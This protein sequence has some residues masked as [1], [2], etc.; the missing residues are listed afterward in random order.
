MAFIDG[1]VVTVALPVL[2]STF[3]ASVADVQWII[4]SYALLLSSLLLAGGAA[5]DLFGRRLVYIAGTT[6]FALAS[7]FCGLSTDIRMLIVSRAVQGIGAALLV[8]GS[9]AII[10]ASFEEK[11]RGRAIGTWSGFT[12]ITAA[13]GPVLGGWLVEHASWRWIFFI[14]VPVAIVVLVLVTQHVPE[15]KGG[16]RD[17][18]LDWIGAALASVGLGGMV[19]GLI[20]SSA[21]GW[22]DPTV[23]G[24]MI[25]GFIALAGFLFRETRAPNPM[26]PLDLFRSRNFSGA[27]L[28]TLFQYAAL[29]GA[30]FFLP[31]ELVQVQGYTPT[32]AGAAL[33]PFILIM[34]VLSRWSGG[35]VRRVGAKL[36]LVVGPIITVLAFALLTMQTEGRSYWTT[37]FPGIIVLGFG[38]ALVVAPLTTTVMNAVP[39]D[40]AGIAS[41]VNNAVSRVAGLLAVAIFGIL[42]VSVF[43]HRL[44]RSLHTLDLAPGVRHSIEEQRTKLA[45]IEMPPGIAP[46][47]A[48][49]IRE[50]IGRSYTAGFRSVMLLS[51]LLSLLSALW[52]WLIIR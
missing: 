38:M 19:F 34:F 23:A 51:S 22:R 18:R 17:R 21:R 6:L 16:K 30:L 36:P 45:A 27:N 44:D 43:N 41:G 28:L 20:E 42:L 50:T 46:G 26:L 10:S 52:A 11:D 33:L 40:R 39:Q 35:L 5:G 47:Q 7:V 13:I 14:N 25:G 12:S 3:R 1:T 31:F 37:F 49:G 9:L 32:Q 8:P 29:S 48:E 24:S 2:Q 15:S 4:E